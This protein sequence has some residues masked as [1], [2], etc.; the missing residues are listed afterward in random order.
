M[1]VPSF[2]LSPL[3]CSGDAVNPWSWQSQERAVSET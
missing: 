3:G 1:N 2:R